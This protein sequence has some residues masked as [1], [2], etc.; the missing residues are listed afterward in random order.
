MSLL[1]VYLSKSILIVWWS[2]NCVFIVCIVQT[3]VE[4]I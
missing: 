1:V 4:E 2:E 3:D